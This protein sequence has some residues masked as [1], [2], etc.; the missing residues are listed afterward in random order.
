MDRFMEA[1]IGE[2]ILG[3]ENRDGGPFGAVVV[4]DGKIVGKGHNMVI[5][6]NDPTAHGE[7]VAIR[8]ACSTLQTFD[9]SGCIL[10]TTCEPCPMCY[11]AIHWSRI[12]KIFY[13][14]TRQ[15]AAKVGFDD[16]LLYDILPR[17]DNIGKIQLIQINREECMKVFRQYEADEGKQL[18]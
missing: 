3:V 11:G 2:A 12:I 17:Q 10:Y 7:V 9:L 16:Q 5:G 8:N 18:Y 15:D 13:G 4:K 14:A 1:A 6:T